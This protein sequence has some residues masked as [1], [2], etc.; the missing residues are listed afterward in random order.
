MTN[1]ERA[2]CRFCDT[3]LGPADDL[4]GICPECDEDQDEEE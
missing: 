2:Y 3:E 1:E 4:D